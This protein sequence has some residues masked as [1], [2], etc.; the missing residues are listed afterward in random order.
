MCR[1]RQSL[2]KETS[3]VETLSIQFYIAHLRCLF[4]KSVTIGIPWFIQRDHKRN[5]TL[6]EEKKPFK[7]LARLNLNLKSRNKVHLDLM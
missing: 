4:T 3:R 7:S 2:L 5:K 6:T 1:N